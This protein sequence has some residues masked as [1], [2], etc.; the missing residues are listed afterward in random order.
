M[1]PDHTGL[2]RPEAQT[3]NYY[4]D[5]ATGALN[6]VVYVSNR[7]LRTRNDYDPYGRV[8]EQAEAFE[9]SNPLRKRRTLTSYDDLART[10]TVTQD[11]AGYGDAAIQS[12]SHFDQMG[13]LF[14]QRSPDAAG[15]AVV[16][17]YHLERIETAGS[18]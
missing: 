11:A 14:L 16:K 4:Y 3:R 2:G 8:N 5:C 1:V 12:V 15:A 7:N 9:Q 6:D 17:S 10:V 13:R 18:Q